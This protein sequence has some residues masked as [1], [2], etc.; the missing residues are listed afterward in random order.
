M[1]PFYCWFGVVFLQILK[2]VVYQ[3]A[4][5]FFVPSPADQLGLSE[6]F[7]FSF[8]LGIHCGAPLLVG[9]Q[10]NQQYFMISTVQ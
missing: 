4:M 8:Y 1:L 5:I 10:V 9:L 6:V 3:M 7:Y 2:A